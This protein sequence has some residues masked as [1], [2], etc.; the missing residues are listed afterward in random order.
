[1]SD[2]RKKLM[3]ILF[4]CLGVFLGVQSQLPK[5]ELQ[6]AELVPADVKIG[7]K[8]TFGSIREEATSWIVIQVKPESV[9]MITEGIVDTIA[10]YSTSDV[11]GS[12]NAIDDYMEDF[13][14]N[15]KKFQMNNM[16]EQAII[17]SP[18]IMSKSEV[19]GG[20]E[21]TGVFVD[22]VDSPYPYFN[23]TKNR[24]VS[25]YVS[26]PHTTS[27]STNG[28]Y[29]G[30]RTAYSPS[31]NNIVNV[32]PAG[33][34]FK[35]SS[36]NTIGIRPAVEIYR[37]GLLLSP[38]YANKEGEVVVREGETASLTGSVL[39]ALSAT[40]D[41]VIQYQVSGDTNQ[42]EFVEDSSNNKRAEIRA[43]TDLK[44]GVY[45]L[46]IAANDKNDVLAPKTLTVKVLKA[47]PT[48]DE[49]SFAAETDISADVASG[50]TLGTASINDQNDLKALKKEYQVDDIKF[51]I[52]NTSN[53][54]LTIDPYTGI[55]S[56]TGDSL[57]TGVHTFDLVVNFIEGT[58]TKQIKKTDCSI[59]VGGEF[60]VKFKGVLDTLVYR[61]VKDGIS[62]TEAG[63]KIGTLSLSTIDSS[64]ITSISIEEGENGALFEIKNKNELYVKTSLDAGTYKLL[65]KVVA[66][67]ITKEQTITIEIGKATPTLEFQ[68]KTKKEVSIGD[69]E[70]TGTI[71]TGNTDTLQVS[72]FTY[73]LKNG[74]SDVVS[75]QADINDPKTYRIQIAQT[76]TGIGLPA[77]YQ[78]HASIKETKNYKAVTTSVG[79]E[80]FVYK[81]LSGLIWS[82]GKN[83]FSA[84]DVKN[85]G[86]V[87]GTLLAKDGVK[88]YTYEMVPQSDPNYDPELGK[89]NSSFTITSTELDKDVKAE[90]KT[91][92]TLTPKTYAIQMK[93]TDN[94]KNVQY[95]TAKIQVKAK[96]QAALEFKDQANGVIITSDGQKVAYNDPNATLFAEGGSTSAAIVYDYAPQD[97]QN[98]KNPNEYL[99][100]NKTSG[101]ITPIQVGT[102]KVMATRPGDA[103]YDAISTYMDVTITPAKQTIQFLNEELT[104]NVALGKTVSE[105]ARG[106]ITLSNE[107]GTGGITY[108][109]SDPSIASI[110][111]SGK[112]TGNKKG[113]VTITAIL[114][115]EAT[116]EY[117]K[118]YE[119]ARS[120]KTIQVYDG[121]N[122]TFTQNAD[123]QANT[124]NT[125]INTPA[126]N[127]KVEGGN[128]EKTFSISKE[129]TNANKDAAL[130]KVNANGV[131][132][133]KKAISA[134]D[135]V[136]SY[137]ST[138]KTYVLYVQVEVEDSAKD[139]VTSN[140][141]ITL[142]GAKL[143]AEFET[144][145]TGK[146]SETYGLDKTFIVSLAENAGGGL[147]VYKLKDDPTMPSDVLKS[148]DAS[149]SITIL[150]ANDKNAN[151]NPVM[152]QA[153]IPPSNGY[154][155]ET[156]EVEVEITKAEQPDF[157]FKNKKLSMSYHAT[158]TPVFQGKLSSGSILLTSENQ[159][160]ATIED[161]DIVSKGESGTLKVSA[162]AGGDRDYKSAKAEAELEITEAAAYLFQ[163]SVPSATYGDAGL[164]A[165]IDLNE[166]EGANQ[167][168][169]WTSSDPTIADIDEDGN[170]T[171]YHAGSVDITCKQTSAD[172]PSVSSTVTL[173]VQPK[174]L[175]VTIEDKQKFVGEALP[176]FSAI[177]KQEDLVDGDVIEQPMFS[178]FES[179]L[180]PVHALTPEGTY[181]IIG[182]YASDAY[183]DYRIEVET[184]T[185]TIEQEQSSPSWFHLETK[186]S[187]IHIGDTQW[188][189]EDVLLLPDTIMGTVQNYDEISI[190]KSSWS[191]VS[192]M[193][194]AEGE[195]DIDVYFR[196]STTQAIAHPQSTQVRIDKT[197][198]IIRGITGIK[199][200][201]NFLEELVHMLTMGSYFK[202][203]I[204]ITIESEDVQKPEVNAI[205][206]VEKI[207]YEVYPLAADGTL[208]EKTEDGELTEHTS[209][210]IEDEGMYV[211]CAIAYD[212][213]GN[214]SDESCSGIRIHSIGE[215]SDDNELPDINIDIDYDGIADINITRP[216]EKFPYLNIDIDGDGIADI[217]LTKQGEEIIAGVT[218]PY[219]NIISSS[220]KWNPQ[221]EIDIDHDGIADFRTDSSL[222]PMLSL[223]SNE[224]GIP[225]L[226]IDIDGNDIPDL[227]I[228]ADGNFVPET[229]IDSDGDGIADINI[230]LIGNGIPSDRICT[231]IIWKPTLMVK[232]DGEILY[233]TTP[234]IKPDALDQLSDNGIVVVPK[235]EDVVFLPNYAIKVTDV[236]NE[237]S[238]RE[239]NELK[240]LISKEEEIKQVLD[241]R[242]FDGEKTIQPDGSI[243]VRIPVDK[244]I[245]NPRLFMKNAK[246]EFEQLQA[247]FKD[248][249][250][251]I[252]V[253]YL[254][255]VFIAGDKKQAIGLEPKP[256]TDEQ[257]TPKPEP[258]PTPSV[259]GNYV[260]SQNGIGGAMTGD[261]T[262][263][264]SYT[265]LL[266]ISTVTLLG[267]FTTK[268]RKN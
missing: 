14:E 209:F 104:R 18:W 120:T 113:S 122:V 161:G 143:N 85:T 131:V 264:L 157:A 215:S 49:L 132:S 48:L 126:G 189:N 249:Y 184:G 2:V 244:N 124:T 42:L 203:E 108:T 260:T 93:V 218:K 114:N 34:I 66:A 19:F 230:D 155:G 101:A 22:A 148:V 195:Q 58:N 111:A 223:D 236:T 33:G 118:N 73:S 164:K 83:V 96:I 79:K 160:L 268:K 199:A 140:L 183:P 210:T 265:V 257:T 62:Y 182:T 70:I 123:L 88:T 20:D 90:V 51:S 145:G 228:D 77:T 207:H 15:K 208:K 121:M 136:S 224:D 134:S 53:P 40:G 110:D 39:S 200:D 82:A 217:N 23:T 201:R 115:K 191:S 89:D 56:Y 149:G 4:A 29:W 225:D 86:T 212:Y 165:S 97:M 233:G 192:Q 240:A 59:L 163:I 6:A 253:Q 241:I 170:I 102:V 50:A 27:H 106:N 30:T 137:D 67:G 81:E 197:K 254:D 261:A 11:N 116:K 214:A 98:G 38:N 84:D 211:V 41:G 174:R 146:I 258:E 158:L 172:E 235:D 68:D 72:D 219:L 142:K 43:K 242:L 251:E 262:S 229:N 252:D 171:I 94:K 267:I 129:V 238:E 190:D 57:A 31:A 187:E 125:A 87:V 32:S 168:Q 1:M 156:I 196:S 17:K 188:V 64:Y 152:I 13:T 245:Q 205:S 75:V 71:L 135:L 8:I 153:I 109:S 5:Q 150:H 173:V 100:I 35:Y 234:N 151:A 194:S 185:L 91:T 213:A 133:F 55:V 255:Q 7:D 139:K 266:L 167:V 181:D 193:I 21:T 74:I 206:G 237:T 186:D 69:E 10:G 16:E 95:T 3:I 250:Y 232:K 179:E 128:G 259:Q 12:V 46:T 141:V 61:G 256:T 107:A 216:N 80:I 24:G 144:G 105:E 25:K 112:V 92:A 227:N 99:E 159:A 9:V 222:I 37:R 169:T 247:E 166:G 103:S 63:N 239:L 202:P 263:H 221:T 45:T 162:I 180:V 26:L 154:E 226:N 127:L 243:L 76:H 117:D 119:T 176:N 65:L 175:H 36:A 220:T 204:E 178:C 54:S 130:F 60:E 177:I 231:E 28:L 138:R 246:G 44:K 198:P 47:Y 78:L 248:G 147:P 52:E